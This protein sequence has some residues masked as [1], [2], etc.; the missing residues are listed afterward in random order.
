MSDEQVVKLIENQLDQ[1]NS[2][3]DIIHNDIKDHLNKDLEYWRKVDQQEA[4][5]SLLRYLAGGTPVV[6]GG[7]VWML[8]RY[9]R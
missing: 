1:L 8:E 2:R 9:L 4:Q 5:L 7:I 6:V 3:L